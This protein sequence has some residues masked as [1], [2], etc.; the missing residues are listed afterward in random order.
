LKDDKTK[1][2]P[3]I[4]GPLPS[5]QRTMKIRM[6]EDDEG[7]TER[8]TSTLG[9]TYPEALVRLRMSS[10]DAHYGGNL[11]DGARMLALFGDIATELLIRHDGDEGLFRAYESVEFLAPVHA[12]DYIEA[13][14]RIIKVGKTSRQM[15]FEAWKVITPRPDLSDSAAELLREPVLVCRAV[16]TCVVPAEKQRPR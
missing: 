3:S 4:K 1:E 7:K 12:G 9:A 16:G 11:V 14:G 8:V 13:V 6:P 10:H 15:S 5:D 2:M